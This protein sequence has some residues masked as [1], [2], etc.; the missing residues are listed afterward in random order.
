MGGTQSTTT[1]AAP[2]ARPV[3]LGGGSSVSGGAPATGGGA[4]QPNQVGGCGAAAP[5][6]LGQAGDDKAATTSGNNGVDGSEW[7]RFF[8]EQALTVACARGREGNDGKAAAA[9]AEKRKGIV[10]GLP[11]IMGTAPGLGDL[12]VEALAEIVG[13][14]WPSVPCIV[15]AGGIF[16]RSI[17]PTN[18]AVAFHPLKHKWA[19]LPPM[20]RARQDAS[21]CVVRNTRLYVTGGSNSET[22]SMNSLDVF[23]SH[24]ICWQLPPGEE[25]AVSWSRM[26][27]PRCNHTAVSVGDCI[28][29]FG[30]DVPGEIMSSESSSTAEFLDTRESQWRVLPSMPVPRRNASGFSVDDSYVCIS[31]GLF[32]GHLGYTVRSCD[33][34]DRRANCWLPGCNTSQMPDSCS[35]HSAVVLGEE[36]SVLVGSDSHPEMNV[37][38]ISS[39]QANDLHTKRVLVLGGVGPYCNANTR[40]FQCMLSKTNE[41]SGR[42]RN[43]SW[44]YHKATLPPLLWHQHSTAVAVA[45]T[46]Y[47]FSAEEEVPFGNNNKTVHVWDTDTDVWQH[48]PMYLN[49]SWKNGVAAVVHSRC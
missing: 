7:F 41:P 11:G 6:L 25:S 46:V 49:K 31:G 37:A 20:T 8:E 18:S 2:V 47:I 1:T 29:V 39:K 14:A 4:R 10:G 32:G 48:F 15:L 13:C 16:D 22:P 38:A 27:W 35:R 19:R 26:C 36:K 5:A 44:S 24:R 28:Y 34:F 9:A 21:A 12:P 23:D 45:N 43:Q 17:G 40:I 30:G 33:T 3:Q 42:Y